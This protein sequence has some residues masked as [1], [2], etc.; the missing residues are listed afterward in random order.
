MLFYLTNSLVV[1]KENPEFRGIFDA[2]K[3]IA[4]AAFQGKHLVLA[5]YDALVLFNEWFKYDPSLSAFFG[6]L[7]SNYSTMVIPPFVRYYIEIVRELNHTDNKDGVGQMEYKDFLDSDCS[8]QCSL[9]AENDNDCKFY[10][11]ILQWFIC[12][13]YPNCAIT[14][15]FTHVNGN[16]GETPSAIIKEL[17]KKH[18]SVCIVDTDVKF[19]GDKPKK[20][21]TCV[22]CREV[23]QQQ[24]FYSY[25]E[26]NVHEIE[27]IIPKN[28][29]FHIENW[30]QNANANKNKE[31]FERICEDPD[32]MRYFDIKEGVLRSQ[33]KGD[34]YY[35]FGARCYNKNPEYVNNMTYEEKYESGDQ[36]IYP[37]LSDKALKKVLS[38]L[39]RRTKLTP[40]ILMD[41]QRENWEMIGALLLDFGIARNSE[42]V[43]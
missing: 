15:S 29:L 10:R 4:S 34:N 36:R 26:L 12:E 27:N 11:H 43:Y 41:F 21:S 39:E 25:L 30:E 28:Y 38:W 23:N 9:I 7:I 32:I 14:T 35:L 19:P 5:D 33:S 22:K 16:G 2:V 40:P 20:D 3:Y 31:S 17:E 13:K 18:V 1:S 8:S 37:G 24:P 6:G 42:V